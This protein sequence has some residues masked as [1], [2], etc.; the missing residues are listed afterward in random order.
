MQVLHPFSLI[1]PK[2]NSTALLPVLMLEQWLCTFLERQH[3]VRCLLPAFRSPGPSCSKVN[4]LPNVLFTSYGLSCFVLL[5]QW[6][7]DAA[8]L[9]AVRGLL[10]T[11][12]DYWPLP[13]TWVLWTVSPHRVNGL[14]PILMSS[15]S[16]NLQPLPNHLDWRKHHPPSTTTIISY[17][18]DYGIAQG[19]AW[20]T[21]T[22]LIICSIISHN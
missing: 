18:L 22:G 6:I 5:S 21:G 19:T 9:W 14:Q 3:L 12:E 20:G 10:R 11:S 8:C 1:S 16:C 2:E 4:C 17:P 13:A 7:T 15:F